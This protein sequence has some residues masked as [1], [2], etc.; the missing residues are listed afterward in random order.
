LFA[1]EQA[2]AL[3]DEGNAHLEA[4]RSRLHNCVVNSLQHPQPNL[5]RLKDE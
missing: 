1:T 2:A 3:V 4:A 5:Y